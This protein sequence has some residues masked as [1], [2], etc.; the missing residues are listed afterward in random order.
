MEALQG[1]YFFLVSAGS[2]R[3]GPKSGATAAAVEAGVRRK[4]QVFST[5]YVLGPWVRRGALGR[6]VQKQALEASGALGG[7]DGPLA[8]DEAQLAAVAYQ[9]PGF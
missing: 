2:I 8:P 3:T 1:G 5:T 4:H 6:N 7:L 9:R